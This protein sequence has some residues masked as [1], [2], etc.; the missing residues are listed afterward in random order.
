MNFEYRTALIFNSDQLS[1]LLFKSFKDDPLG[2]YLMY[3][4]EHTV[5]PLLVNFIFLCHKIISH[6]VNVCF[7]YRVFIVGGRHVLFSLI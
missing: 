1:I 2:F 5:H 7:M 6:F 3:L 4:I